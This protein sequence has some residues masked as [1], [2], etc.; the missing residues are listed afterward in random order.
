MADYTVNGKDYTYLRAMLNH[1]AQNTI[2]NDL[3]NGN[4]NSAYGQTIGLT[5]SWLNRAAAHGA[6]T[7]G[8]ENE[9]YHPQLSNFP[10]ADSPNYA[11]IQ[12]KSQALDPRIAQM[13]DT[14]L[15]SRAAGDP[16]IMGHV[17]QY[18]NKDVTDAKYSQKYHSWYDKSQKLGA[19]GDKRSGGTSSLEQEF[20]NNP[21]WGVPDY[22]LKVGSDVRLNPSE[23]DVNA[24]DDFRNS[25]HLPTPLPPARP[26]DG[27]RGI[28]PRQAPSALDQVGEFATNAVAEVG[29][30]IKG[31]AGGIQGAGDAASGA[32]NSGVDALSGYFS[33]APYQQQS[34]PLPPGR[35]SDGQLSPGVGPND[36]GL[37]ADPSTVSGLGSGFHFGAPAGWDANVPL[38]DNYGAIASLYQQDLG[39]SPDA[40]GAN[41]WG[42]AL[43]SGQSLTQIDQALRNSAEAQARAPQDMPSTGAGTYNPATGA[44]AMQ[45]AQIVDTA[46]RAVLGRPAEAAGSDFWSQ[47]V[48]QGSMNLAGLEDAL[49]RSPE[50]VQTHP[51]Q[52]VQTQI[53]NHLTPTQGPGG[54]TSTALP[55]G[56]SP[57]IA[58]LYESTLH[59]AP[60][61][62]G[63]QFYTGELLSGT[64]T[65]DQIAAELAK[66]P[67]AQLLGPQEHQ[68]AQSFD[69]LDDAY[70][71]YLGRTADAG[72]RSFY[73]GK[74][75]ASID[76]ALYASPEAQ[77][78]RAGLGDQAALIQA[79]E[80]ATQGPG[81]LTPMQGPGALTPTQG[82]GE[83]VTA[84]DGASQF[85]G[86]DPSQYLLANPDVAA[87]D[88]WRNN[89]L[90][91]YETFGYNEGRAVDTFGDHLTGFDPSAYLSQYSDVKAAG[92]DPLEHFLQNGA[93]EGRS[94]TFS[95]DVGPYAFGKYGSTSM[96]AAPP[97]PS[98]SQQPLGSGIT[99]NNGKTQYG[100]VDLGGDGGSSNLFDPV[101]SEKSYL[102]TQV[103]QINAGAQHSAQ[104]EGMLTQGKGAPMPVFQVN[105]TN[106]GN[107]DAVA[108][109]GIAHLN[110]VNTALAGLAPVAPS[111]ASFLPTQGPIFSAWQ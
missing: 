34:V 77:T 59:R 13:L 97:A 55:P 50:Y 30:A 19:F 35:P 90:G 60:D 36:P 86:F 40:D 47:P 6:T 73:A 76:A 66:S 8:L 16:G 33:P 1:E 110:N 37:P 39:R 104:V 68:T 56:T 61:A 3:K 82:P 54:D 94:A 32:I 27:S 107:M 41:Y 84:R 88:Q 2:L 98:P 111:G 72:G 38:P 87:S 31:I 92:K 17:N 99:Y 91:H 103:D 83:G 69:S 15:Q 5:E 95:P 71:H 89:A 22:N 4:A 74:D 79:P 51:A 26:T 78:Y 65:L 10:K 58:Q 62:A 12:Q 96:P 18:L 20:L 28:D 102:N 45:P 63:G 81:A 70:A 49:L 108:N 9:M 53:A 106:Q 105:G 101:S 75:P 43:A 14:Y 44:G 7:G 46:Y 25:Y 57:L 42:K 93:A 109:A 67:E 52:D 80:A 48:Q 21:D 100:G 29:D 85:R 24:L 23:G 11:L 64:N